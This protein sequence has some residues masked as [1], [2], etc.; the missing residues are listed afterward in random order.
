MEIVQ[1]LHTINNVP[2]GNRN[3]KNLAKFRCR[4]SEHMIEIRSN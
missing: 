3:R 2:L 1:Q 4:L